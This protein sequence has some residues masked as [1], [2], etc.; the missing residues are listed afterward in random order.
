MKLIFLFSVITQISFSF[1]LNRQ[2]S[3][4]KISTNL[5]NNKLIEHFINNGIKECR[6][7]RLPNDFNINKYKSLYNDVSIINN[8]YDIKYHYINYGFKEG[9]L[10]KI[11]DNF[12]IDIYKKKYFE[13]IDIDF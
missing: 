10:Y 7:Y 4:Y 8:D 3:S 9:R 6:L 11:P 13:N 2:Y 5:S 1:R 12:N